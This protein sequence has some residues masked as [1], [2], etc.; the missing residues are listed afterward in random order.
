MTLWT[1][2]FWRAAAERSIKTLAQTAA[3]L[4]V[5][6]GTG[7]LDTDWL[8]VTSVAGMAAVVSL[9]TSVGSDALTGDGPSLIDAEALTGEDTH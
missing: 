9:L 7:L 3:A 6:D 2:A 1:L 8:T 4:I 5:A